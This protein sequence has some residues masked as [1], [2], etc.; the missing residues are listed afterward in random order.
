MIPG[1]RSTSPEA[2]AVVAWAEARL[3]SLRARLES[4]SCTD[5]D[6]REFRGRIAELKSLI[7]SA[8]NEGES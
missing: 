8:Q 4:L 7:Q 2:R 5:D 3:T 1:L 6:A